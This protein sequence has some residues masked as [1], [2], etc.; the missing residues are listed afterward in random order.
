MS[1]E[2]FDR[3]SQEI[4]RLEYMRKGQLIRK[5]VFLVDHKDNIKDVKWWIMTLDKK[6][7]IDERATFVSWTEYG[8]FKINK[9]SSYSQHFASLRFKE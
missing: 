4:E 5:V 2:S 6:G 3:W 7:V 8:S 9:I 1:V